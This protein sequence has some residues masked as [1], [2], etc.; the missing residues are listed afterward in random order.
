MTRIADAKTDAARKAVAKQVLK[1][2]RAGVAWDG[3]DGIVAQGFV[4]GAPQGRALL[5]KYGL[6]DTGT[7]IAKSYDRAAYGLKGSRKPAAKKPATRKA[8]A[9][10]AAKRTRKAAK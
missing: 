4:S 7:G 9:K 3:A 2:R 8:A 5:R 10:P 6:A 1:L